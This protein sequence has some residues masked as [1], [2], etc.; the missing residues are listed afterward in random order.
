MY[1]SRIYDWIMEKTKNMRYKIWMCMALVLVSFTGYTQ[2]AF[3]DG[4][5]TDIQEKAKTENKYIF[6]DA[7][8]DWCYWCKEMDK[9]TFMEGDVAEVMNAGFIPVKMDMEKG[10]GV[11]MAMKYRVSSFPTFLIMNPDGKLVHT[12]TGFHEKDD[13]IA[14]LNTALEQSRSKG[15]PGIS[16]NMEPDFPEFYKNSF[17]GYPTEK[18]ARPDNKTIEQYLEKND[19]F[20]EESWSVMTR[21][22]RQLPKYQQHILDNRSKYEELFGKEEVA[23]RV[24]AIIYAKLG[25]AIEK[26]DEEVL[27]STLALIDRHIPDPEK[28]KSEYRIHYYKETAQWIKMDKLVQESIVKNGISES[29]NE[30][31]WAVYEN[32]DQKDVIRDAIGWMKL[33]CDKNPTYASL[34]TYAALLYKDKQ[35]AEAERIASTAI[36]TGGANGQDVKETEVLLEKIRTAKATK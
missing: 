29:L 10:M 5:W 26:R 23:V 31:G 11:K 8:T 27:N 34:D 20:S 21:F 16:E 18:V 33:L 2:V 15:Y 19:L 14:S 36:E 35:Y 12:M 4:S 17:K 30:Y 28:H 24:V 9:K 32:C 1:F 7:Y 13:F 6:V 25:E 3:V 22:I